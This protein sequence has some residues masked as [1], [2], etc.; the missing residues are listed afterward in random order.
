MDS[1]EK[2]S[3]IDKVKIILNK[4][5][6]V[7]HFESYWQITDNRPG[8]FNSRLAH[9]NRS[10]LHPPGSQVS[11]F[12]GRTTTRYKYGFSSQHTL[13]ILL[14]DESSKSLGYTTRIPGQA[15]FFI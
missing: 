9:I 11:R 7:R 12:I 13:A 14:F 8:S 15:A 5:K 4:F 1:T 6:K 3:L 2:S 10:Y